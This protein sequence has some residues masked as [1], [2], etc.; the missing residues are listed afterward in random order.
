M[1]SSTVESHLTSLTVVVSPADN[2][3]DPKVKNSGLG[4]VM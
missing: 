1:I 4:V 3:A 2:G